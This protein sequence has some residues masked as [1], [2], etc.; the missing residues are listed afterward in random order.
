M[1]FSFTIVGVFCA[2]QKKKLW[3]SI[4]IANIYGEV[5]IKKNKKS[6]PPRCV[7]VWKGRRRGGGGVKADEN[8]ALLCTRNDS[9][10]RNTMARW[11][12]KGKSSCF[13]KSSCGTHTDRYNGNS[14]SIN[15]HWLEKVW[16]N[17]GDGG[18]GSVREGGRGQIHTC[19]CEASI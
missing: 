19:S 3:H 1:Q 14:N 9:E 6:Y 7:A 10:I 13:K 16:R 18:W 11:P 15:K 12:T 5:K 2:E 4:S 17:L 8:R